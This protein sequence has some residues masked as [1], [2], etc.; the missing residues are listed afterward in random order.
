VPALIAPTG[1]LPEEPPVPGLGSVPSDQV[2][3]YV[4]IILARPLF[5]PSRRPE[6]VATTKATDLARLT[7]VVMSPAGKSAI[8]AGSKGAKPL[9]VREGGRIG[10]YVVSSIDVGAVTV[11][12]PGGTRVLHLA[13]DSSPPPP[14]PIVAAKPGIPTALVTQFQQAM[15][16]YQAQQRGQ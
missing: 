8:F 14:K 3:R 2:A 13:F 12:S 10:E 15:R 4:A 7:G 1:Q 11:T 6:D 9:V 5:S 16:D